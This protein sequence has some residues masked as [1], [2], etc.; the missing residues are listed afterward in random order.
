MQ[1]CR[2]FVL[3]RIEKGPSRNHND[4]IVSHATLC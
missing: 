3:C 1:G 2:Q 4:T